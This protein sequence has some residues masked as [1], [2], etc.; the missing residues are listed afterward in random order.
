MAV[1][2]TDVNLTA[3]YSELNKFGK[4]GDYSRAIKVAKK[5]KHYG[6]IIS[7]TFY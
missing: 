7:L 6:L 4:N 1:P 2:K 5:S 3:L